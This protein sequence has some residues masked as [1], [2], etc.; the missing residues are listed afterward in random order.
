MSQ[1][2]ASPTL[3]YSFHPCA[4]AFVS[5][6]SDLMNPSELQKRTHFWWVSGSTLF[7][8]L[9]APCLFQMTSKSFH[10]RA[11]WSLVLH[12]GSLTCFLRCD[13]SAFEL[14]FLRPSSSYMILMRF[15]FTCLSV[16]PP[17]PWTFISS[18][19]FGPAIPVLLLVAVNHHCA[20]NKLPGHWDK[21]SPGQPQLTT[22][23][24]HPMLSFL[25]LFERYTD[26]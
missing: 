18:F 22:F 14:C 17:F 23:L 8:V 25:C 10:L 21:G 13:V 11:L 9:S 5:I 3:L 16:H 2:Q 6:L 20:V 7:L 15:L 12:F 4:P 1:F 24:Q 19:G 26:R